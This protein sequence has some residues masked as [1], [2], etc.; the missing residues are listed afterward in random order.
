[1]LR[2]GAGHVGLHLAPGYPVYGILASQAGG[3]VPPPKLR[4]DCCQ[5]L[6]LSASFEQ[7]LRL[8]GR[9]GAGGLSRLPPEANAKP[10][11]RILQH[12]TL[13]NTFGFEWVPSLAAQ[14]VQG[15]VQGS[16]G[17]V[18]SR[19]RIRDAQIYKALAKKMMQSRLA[20]PAYGQ[21]RASPPN[22]DGLLA[23]LSENHV[24]CFGV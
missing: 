9:N 19:L 6:S 18:S 10:R 4:W 22:A 13:V 1:M 14:C 8:V 21:L 23:A 16:R 12:E 11:T 24:G 17:H 5:C 15:V 3:V 20:G 7:G 2:D